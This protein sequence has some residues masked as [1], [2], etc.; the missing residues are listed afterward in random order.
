MLGRSDVR[1]SRL[2]LGVM[3]WGEASGLQQV[4]PAKIAYGGT[5]AAN[6]QAAFEA[7]LAAQ[8]NFFDTAAMY[9]GGASERRLGEL[10]RGKEIVIAS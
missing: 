4:M 6:E 2:G 10:A 7:T 5:D 8:V 3:V 9:S 1:V